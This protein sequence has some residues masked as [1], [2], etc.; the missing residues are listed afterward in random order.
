M[1]IHKQ[2]MLIHNYWSYAIGLWAGKERT[3]KISKYYCMVNNYIQALITTMLTVFMNY[4]IYEFELQS[5]Q[6]KCRWCVRKFY[7]ND[8][9]MHNL[10]QIFM[11]Q[12]L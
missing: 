5:A 7:V 1:P 10:K 6:R 9:F 8:G 2:D 3:N 4:C 11:W 12:V